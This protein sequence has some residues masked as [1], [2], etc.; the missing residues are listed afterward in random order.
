MATPASQ[1]FT[2][3]DFGKF[4]VESSLY[5]KVYGNFPTSKLPLSL[6]DL[7]PSH[8]YF[9]CDSSSC[10]RTQAFIN[11]NS[12]YDEKERET[13]IKERDEYTR[14]L[15]EQPLASRGKGIMSLAVLAYSLSSHGVYLIRYHCSVCFHSQK[16]W[17]VQLG[18][19]HDGD[20]FIQKVGQLPPYDISISRDLKKKLNEEDLSLYKQAQVC[21]SQNY[22]IGACIYLRRLIENQ[23]DK[24]LQILLETRQSEGAGDK[25]LETIKGI[26]EEKMLENKIKL[27]TQPD[28]ETGVNLVGRMY[29]RLSDAIHNRNDDQCTT[30]AQQVADLFHEVLVSLKQRQES[31]RAYLEKIKALDIPDRPKGSSS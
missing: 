1:V 13:L 27:V 11:N 6:E 10:K 9:E 25:E 18:L 4:L 21:I 26:I 5:Q 7:L 2:K 3:E 15:S 29:D 23:I 28:P 24:L 14:K 20:T 31:Q 30:I 8:L 22:G 12:H 19:G 16:M 17:W